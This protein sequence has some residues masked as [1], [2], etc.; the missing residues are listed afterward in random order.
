MNKYTQTYVKKLIKN[1]Q[2]KTVKLAI[3]SV[4]TDN[5]YVL[6]TIVSLLTYMKYYPN[7]TF[8]LGGN[9]SLKTKEIITSHNII[10]ID[11]NS[12]HLFPT[13][14]NGP[15]PS[16]C[17]WWLTLPEY[18]LDLNYTHSL[19]VD[20]DTLCNKVIHT[21][22]IKN[23]KSVI[24]FNKVNLLK[25]VKY[26]DKARQNRINMKCKSVFNVLNFDVETNYKK[27]IHD[28]TGIENINT[29]VML[30]NN[31]TMKEFKL[32]E[33]AIFLFKKIIDN[34]EF[35][36]GD[37]SFL[38]LIAL[39]YSNF[40]I[41][42]CDNFQY[43]EGIT[44]SK[45]SSCHIIH[46]HNPKPWS[47]F[48]NNNLNKYIN[49]W[50]SYIPNTINIFEQKP[51]EINMWWWHGHNNFGDWVGPW[52]Y[53]KKTGNKISKPI[54]SSK[55]SSSIYSVGSIISQLR[56]NAIVW[57]SGISKLI[58][59]PKSFD[60][61]EIRSVR[62]PL[63]RYRLLE[64]DL[65]TPEKYGDA[66]MIMPKYLPMNNN[67]KPYK[68]GIIP[69]YT[70][71][72]EFLKLPIANDPRILIIDLGTN[73]VDSI[74][75]KLELCETTVSTSLHGVIVSVAYNIPTRWIM[76]SNKVYG[77]HV[78]YWDFFLSLRHK[79]T[80][81]I[82]IPQILEIVKYQMLHQEW[83]EK[84]IYSELAEYFPIDFRNNINSITYDKLYDNV[85][86]YFITPS[87]IEDINS[88]CPF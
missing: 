55:K 70:D 78:K 28:N 63:T 59:K 65:D 11:I 20:G 66:A 40:L 47:D 68:L 39:Y 10:P 33:K 21:T 53:N 81:S 5:K 16:E 54:H 84:S 14:I 38:A 88:T 9:F 30:F 62:G 3:F 34:G 71:Y 75:K 7:A 35:W 22:F 67:N 61:L 60:N 17:F 44:K 82:L 52:L 86:K 12:K 32:G 51:Q 36:D 43:I 37:D 69:H 58:I 24:G 74:I 50:R 31:K 1:M 15:Y 79:S 57:G 26:A 6:Y 42:Y 85:I 19:Y 25:F 45:P 49:I 77:D 64:L 83:P 87:L 48:K 29:G 41:E 27:R 80:H 18:F 73:N 56:P 8:Y 13:R 4:S 76:I 72:E 23:V 46:I 2:N